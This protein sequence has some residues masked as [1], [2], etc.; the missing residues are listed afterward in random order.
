MSGRLAVDLRTTR[1]SGVARYG[2]SM[3]GPLL[4]AAGDEGTE[5]IVIHRASQAAAVGRLVEESR[6]ASPGP[7][8]RCYSIDGEDG[9]VRRSPRLRDLLL[10]EDV[11]LYYT[12]HYLADP[13][14]PV[15]FV[16]T[17]HDLTRLRF[18]AL[19]YTDATFVAEF[20]TAEL[21]AMRSYL[22]RLGAEHED[23]KGTEGPSN[24]VFRR[25]FRALNIDL[26]SRAAHVMAVS[27]ATRDDVVSL[28]GVDP[29][30]VSLAPC[31]V[32]S[33][34]FHP[35]SPAEVAAVRDRFGLPGPYLLF[36]GAT[37][38]HKRLEWLVKSLWDAR[39]IGPGAAVLV[40]L[41]GDRRQFSTA[42]SFA[43]DIGCQP[44]VTFPGRVSDE[45]L[46]ALYTGT[47]ALVGAS[48]NEGNNLPPLEAMACGA[49][50]LAPAIPPLQET[51]GA[52]AHFYSPESA[53]E[54]GAMAAAA[55]DGTLA[56]RAAAF[57]PQS[58]DGSAAR[59]FAVLR[60][61]M[62]S[63]VA[64]SPPASVALEGIAATG[65]PR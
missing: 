11:D 50:V 17:I 48:L 1:A 41:G 38:P 8:A 22:A 27:E 13:A 18:P 19:T 25:Y 55:V 7:P 15:P 3:L 33:S 56:R 31:G 61:A 63:I 59:L 35:R 32:D 26:A 54:V 28:L 34:T 40:V 21:D 39:S 30:R 6:A 43:A 20:G 46:A 51:L 12:S 42:E 53:P 4:R 65:G 47:A 14:C 10:A 29:R 57:D 49:E 36:V 16:F 37:H 52:A 44:W 24:S 2:S 23:G 58:W 45:E 9:F 64:A 62:S 60:D 5:T